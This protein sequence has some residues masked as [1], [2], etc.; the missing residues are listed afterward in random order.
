MPTRRPTPADREEAVRI[1]LDG[2]GTGRDIHDVVIEIHPLHPKN[3]TFP[4]EVFLELAADA[5]E[6]SGASRS[7]PI[8]YEG[9]RERYLPECEFR[10][11]AEHDKSYYALSAVAMIRAGVEPDLLGE[12]GWWNTDDFWIYALY[13]LAVYLRVA[14]DCTSRPLGD[15][16]DRIGGRRDAGGSGT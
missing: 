8:E 11:R 1:A 10:G 15:V 3:N 16:C 14:A 13:A 7:Q 12:V 5:L 9:I 2:I 4:G 6:L